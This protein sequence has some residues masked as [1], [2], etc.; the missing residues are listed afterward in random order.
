MTYLDLGTHTL[1]LDLV[2]ATNVATLGTVQ[3]SGSIVK[4][5]LGTL[6]FATAPNSYT[7]STLVQA[8][9]AALNGGA[10][11]STSS[12]V[13]VSAG[14]TFDVSAIT[15]ASTS[16]TSLSGAG[17][18]V[19]GSKSLTLTN[20]NNVFSGVLSGT[21][22]LTL[23][24]GA[25]TLS[26]INTYQGGTFLNAGVLSVAADNNLGDAAGAL[27]FNGGGLRNSSAFSSA[28]AVTLAGNGTFQTDA[29]LTLSSAISGAGALIKTGSGVLTLTG[30]NSYTGNTN[31]NAGELRVNNGGTITG[32]AVT[33]IIG[34]N[35]VLRVSGTGSSWDTG[36][37][38]LARE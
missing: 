17:S 9:T 8:G 34:A 10:S 31:I 1:T 20:A 29:D 27:T 2:N 3:G 22:G 16:I 5:G 23:T 7:G 14:A 28:R 19:L 11:I 6:T 12:V 18:V 24:G 13:D 36:R 4:T 38:T 21:G 25:Q 35:S 26:G 33:S 30:G 15:A 32:T 37:L